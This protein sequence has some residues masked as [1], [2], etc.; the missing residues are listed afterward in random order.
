M[1]FSIFSFCQQKFSTQSNHKAVLLFKVKSLRDW[2]RAFLEPIWNIPDLVNEVSIIFN[3]ESFTVKLGYN[4]LGYNELGYNE[5]GC[6]RT[7]GYNEQI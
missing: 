4:E 3:E 5:L 2:D 6:W 1:F 7:L